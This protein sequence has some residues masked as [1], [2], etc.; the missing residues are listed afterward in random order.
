MRKGAL[1]A[2]V[3][4]GEQLGIGIGMVLNPH[5]AATDLRP[6]RYRV[7]FSFSFR[8]AG[9]DSFLLLNEIPFLHET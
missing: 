2:Q 8:P 9:Q 1:A 3:Q 7:C 6:L 5:W 4:S